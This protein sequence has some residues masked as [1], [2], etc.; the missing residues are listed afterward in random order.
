MANN[1]M[2]LVCQCGSKFMIAKRMAGPWFATITQQSLNEWFEDRGHLTAGG[3]HLCTALY[4][5]YSLEYE[6]PPK[7]EI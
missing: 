5:I 6:H 1:R 3:R 7:E 2:Y 4:E